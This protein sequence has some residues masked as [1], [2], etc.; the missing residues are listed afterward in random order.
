MQKFQLLPKTQ[1]S[2]VNYVNTVIYNVPLLQMILLWKYINR[3]RHTY[4]DT[5][6]RE[7]HD[8]R[9][10]VTHLWCHGFGV[11]RGFAT[12]LHIGVGLCKIPI[13][14]LNSATLKTPCLV[15]D[16]WPYLSHKPSYS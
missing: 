14:M 2:T 1:A 7:T 15:Q 10:F 4:R 6:D 11:F 3:Q 8:I 5:Q 16:C 12:F 13:R 9:F